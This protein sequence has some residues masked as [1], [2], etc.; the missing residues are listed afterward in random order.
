MP[1]H[2]SSARAA[3]SAASVTST[4]CT[5]PYSPEAPIVAPELPA[6]AERGGDR[7]PLGT[8]SYLPPIM[9]QMLAGFVLR[10]IAG[11]E[12]ALGASAAGCGR[13]NMGGST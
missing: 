3:A 11:V 13:E 10:R 6:R 1:S 5:P 8:T 9:G 2:A 12:D 7:P 4:C